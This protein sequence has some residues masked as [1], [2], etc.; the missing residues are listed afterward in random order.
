[1]GCAWITNGKPDITE[2]GN[3]DE[4]KG[5]TFSLC[6]LYC[7]GQGRKSFPLFL[8]SVANELAVN[9]PNDKFYI[10]T[11]CNEDLQ[12]EKAGFRKIKL[13]SQ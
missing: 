4:A 9:N 2:Q 5:E 11:N 6:A 8:Q 3:V 7:H 13:T 12:F 10:I 1:L